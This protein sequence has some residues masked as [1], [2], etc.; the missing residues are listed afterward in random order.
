MLCKSIT[1]NEATE[2]CKSPLS[3]HG[4][5]ANIKYDGERIKAIKKDGEVFLM[6]RRGNIKNG[7]YTE[8]V[9]E[10]ETYNFNFVIDG[11][12]ISEDDNFNLLQKRALTKDKF[13]QQQLRKTIPVKYMVFDILEIDDNDLRNKPLKERIDYSGLFKDKD[14]AVIELAEYKSVG[15]MLR[16]A[17]AQSREGIVIKEMDGRYHE[18]K[19]HKNWLKC[20]FFK[21]TTIELISYTPNNAGIRCEDALKNAVQISGQQHLAVKEILDKGQSVEVE[22]QYLEITKDGRFR[23]P[24]F[25]GIKERGN[26]EGLKEE[27]LNHD[28]WL[29]ASEE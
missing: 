29:E 14:N 15:E 23:F 11:E 28:A 5:K 26:K 6:N 4:Q 1:E 27:E 8:V 16:T 10:L 12:V 3:F 20:K 7:N 22:I 21:E 17:K 13:K 9:E 25:R 24:S 19:R 2:K 18:N